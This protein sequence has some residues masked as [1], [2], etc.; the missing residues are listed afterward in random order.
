LTILVTGSAGHLGE[1][2]MRTLGASGR[3][4]RGLDIK[5]SPFTDHVGSVADRA[6][7]AGAM[8]GVRGVIHAATL[9]K[10]HVATHAPQDFVDVNVTGT[11]AL[12]E[13]ALA[14]GV[15]AFVFTS[16]TSAFGSALTPAAGAP[17]AWITEAVAPVPKNIYGA[18]KLAAEAL[19]ELFA[20]RERLPAV[21]LR[22]ARFFPE[23]DDDPELRGAY[24]TANAQANEMLYRRA[25]IEDVADAHL[26][27]L[28]RAP[29]IGFGKYIVSAT[30]PFSPADLAALRADAPAVVARLFP[31]MPG[32]YAAKGWRMFAGIDRVYVNRGAVDALGW[33]PRRDFRFVLDCLARG[34]DFRSALAVAVG[35]KGYHDR[36]FDEGPYPVA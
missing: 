10:P 22:T 33:R 23:P 34:E 5:P 4:A 3:A 27:A 2:L 16:T 8:P 7:V 14:A 32:L 19:V 30:T 17:A 35:A 11:L 9:H 36:V 24:Y 29:E 6:F 21:I 25:D 26:L 18:T 28:D 31:D 13:A 20:R 1:A 15:A 12:L